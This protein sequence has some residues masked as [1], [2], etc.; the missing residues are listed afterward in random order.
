V[1]LSFLNDHIIILTGGNVLLICQ[2]KRFVGD[3][4]LIFEESLINTP[5]MTDI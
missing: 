4:E 3:V 1:N 2:C 5:E